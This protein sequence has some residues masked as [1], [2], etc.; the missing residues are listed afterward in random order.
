MLTF[1][2]HI[3]SGCNGKDQEEK[4]ENEGLQVVCGH[5]L[6]PKENCAQQL[7]LEG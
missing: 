7:A 1:N 5:P 2:P 6:D 4:D 3:G